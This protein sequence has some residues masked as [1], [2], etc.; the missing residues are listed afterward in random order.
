M[1]NVL[2][3]IIIGLLVAFG[4]GF[5]LV[6]RHYIRLLDVAVSRAQKSNQLKSVFIDNISRT[7]RSPLNAITGYCNMI[8]EEKDENLQPAQVRKM[9]TDISESSKE[10]V[11]FVMQLH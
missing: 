10:I 5:F 7:L 9:V 2:I 8:L 3:L 1:M 4:I 6:R 11:E